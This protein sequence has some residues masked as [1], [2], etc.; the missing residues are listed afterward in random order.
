M[1]LA[2]QH[3]AIDG[4]LARAIGIQDLCDERPQRDDGRE[5]P[6]ATG[7]EPLLQA[8]CHTGRMELGVQLGVM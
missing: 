1:Q 8:R 5:E 7:C 6:V 3:Q 4:V 2:V